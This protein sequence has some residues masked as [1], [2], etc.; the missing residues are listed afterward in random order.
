LEQSVHT[1][2]SFPSVQ[3]TQN[4]HL[5]TLLFKETR[6]REQ[7]AV[8]NQLYKDQVLS[9]QSDLKGRLLESTVQGSANESIFTFKVANADSPP[10]AD[11]DKQALTYLIGPPEGLL[12][13]IKY[14]LDP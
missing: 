12:N 14:S 9:F 3:D 10:T 8:F 4:S 11:K 1:S 7:L 6:N 13:L 2:L 5:A